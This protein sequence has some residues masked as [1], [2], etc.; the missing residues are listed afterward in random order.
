MKLEIDEVHSESTLFLVNQGDE[1]VGPRD[2]AGTTGTL[3]FTGAPVQI[4]ACEGTRHIDDVAKV[5]SCAA[6]RRTLVGEESEVLRFTLGSV[7]NLGTTCH[8]QSCPT[9]S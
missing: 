7:P 5:V 4:L 1:H 2:C 3:G 9:I 8:K 6:T